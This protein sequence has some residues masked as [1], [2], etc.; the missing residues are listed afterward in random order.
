[1]AFFSSS[2]A[3]PKY[4]D[5]LKKTRNPHDPLQLSKNQQRLKS[6][7][8]TGLKAVD[9]VNNVIQ[10]TNFQKATEEVATNY[11]TKLQ[12]DMNAKSKAYLKANRAE[13]RK[14]SKM[15]VGEWLEGVEN[16]LIEMKT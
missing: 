3:R 14:F 2:Q 5:L 1:M 6:N 4:F 12:K 10:N 9:A 16:E 8:K 15:T 7:L 13:V 11:F